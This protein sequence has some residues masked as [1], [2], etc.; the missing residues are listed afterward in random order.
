MVSGDKVDKN[1]PKSCPQDL[2]ERLMTYP[3]DIERLTEDW[4]WTR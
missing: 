4:R 2:P 1:V 3:G